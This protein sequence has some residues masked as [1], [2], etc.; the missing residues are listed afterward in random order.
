MNL[1]Y[2][3]ALWAADGD[4]VLVDD[5]KF[6]L[7]A[8]APL[9]DYAA[10]VL[11]VEKG[12][13]PRLPIDHVEPWGWDKRIRAELLDS[14]IGS[15]LVPGDEY[16]SGVRSLSDRRHTSEMLRQLRRG[17]E[18]A[19]CGEAFLCESLADVEARLAE[20]GSI[21]VKAPW[22]SSG[23]GVRYADG[24]I[25]GAKRAWI[26]KTIARQGHVMA[27]PHYNK[28]CDF[29]LEFVAGSDGSV[30]YRGLS[31]FHAVNGQY[32][33]NVIAP[34]A[35]KEERL[36]RY[37]RKPLLEALAG[38]L[39]GVLGEM[40]GKAYRGPL[41]VDMMV[42]ADGNGRLLVD[43]CVEINVRRT[44]GHVALSLA[45]KDFR[46]ASMMSI[47]HK[48]NYELRLDRIEGEFVIM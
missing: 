42:V 3:P 17:M 39:E 28:V 33:G 24:G 9:R 27:E 29:A 47:V 10:D 18:D 21:V 44:M 7:K 35:N 36:G 20:Y 41:G 19:T 23:R 38:R 30:E 48:V 43:P 12:D 45:E 34:E 40:L 1:G 14:G 5:M 6:A 8:V 31:V 15:Q 32:T 26:E 13:L 37:V 25:D 4:C 22:S 11:F 16:L 46:F 2:L